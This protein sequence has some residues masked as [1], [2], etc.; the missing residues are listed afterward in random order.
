M[1]LQQKTVPADA[2]VEQLRRIMIETKYSRLP[3]YEET[4]DEITGIVIARDLMRRAR[5]L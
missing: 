1:L 2:T 3:V 5:D 4:L